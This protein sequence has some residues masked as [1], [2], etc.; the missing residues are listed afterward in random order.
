M[1]D[2]FRSCLEACLNALKTAQ[3]CDADPI[4]KRRSLA[5]ARSQLQAIWELVEGN[6]DL[7]ALEE[8]VNVLQIA[9][10]VEGPAALSPGQ[11]DAISS[12]VAKMEDDPDLSDQTAND[13]TREL[14][15]GRV[16]VF[17]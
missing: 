4:L 9:L 7:E 17:R 14:I 12:V 5:D 2:I 11:L 3:V 1:T 6:A 16:D 13:L 10:S 15:R 8:M